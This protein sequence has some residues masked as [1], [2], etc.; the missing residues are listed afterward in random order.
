MITDHDETKGGPAW[1]AA[2]TAGEGFEAPGVSSFDFP[3]L[4]PGRA[5]V[6]KYM[7]QAIVSLFIILAFWLIMA[8]KNRLVP[9]KGQFVG[10]TAYFFVRNSIARDMHRA[11]TSGAACRCSSRC[12]P[13]SWSTTCGASS[14]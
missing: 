8:R 1:A 13:S 14:R 2:D 6:D 11:T 9:S 12:S 10:E 3:P 7:F 4:V 5:V